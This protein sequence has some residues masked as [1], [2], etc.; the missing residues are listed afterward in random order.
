MRHMQWKVARWK[1][2]RTQAPRRCH[3]RTTVVQADGW[4]HN[5]HVPHTC[6]HN[7]RRLSRYTGVGLLAQSWI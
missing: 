3:V 4:R 1:V 2:V 5:S 7:V 6:V